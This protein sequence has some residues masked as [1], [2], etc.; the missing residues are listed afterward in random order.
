MISTPSSPSATRAFSDSGLRGDSA[1][2]LLYTSIASSLLPSWRSTSAR[3]SNACARTALFSA[4]TGS[5]AGNVQV[6]LV[7]RNDRLVSDVEATEKVRAALRDAL[8]GIQV[9]F[10]TGGIVKR[11]LNMGSAAPIDIE[12]LG[13]DV[14][15]G[16]R[17]A[18]DLLSKLNAL[19]D[20]RR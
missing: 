20:D 16:S 17:F 2:R 11:F 5:H 8:P 12:I 15:A 3:P 19:S 14:D 6:N 9:Y 18:R 4:N 10:F 7:S 13:Y 1:S